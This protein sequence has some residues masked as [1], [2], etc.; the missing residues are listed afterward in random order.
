MS[1][2]FLKLSDFIQQ[3]FIYSVKH[4]IATLSCVIQVCVYNSSHF[5]PSLYNELPF[6]EPNNIKQSIN[7][8]RAEFLAGRIVAAMALFKEGSPILSVTNGARREPICYSNYNVS[9]THTNEMS[10]AIAKKSSFIYGVGVDCEKI[11]SL[12]TAKNLSTAIL[13]GNDRSFYHKDHISYEFFCT[14]VFSAKEALFK[15]I[16]SHIKCYVGFEAAMLTKVDYKKQTFE[17]IVSEDIQLA[18]SNNFSGGYKVYG[19]HII[20]FIIK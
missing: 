13:C 3:S 11:M 19:N 7:K 18:V 15:T 8:R 20:T 17:I 10:A 6:S 5:N 16:Y 9:I 2:D 1:T 14:L 4:D 12:K